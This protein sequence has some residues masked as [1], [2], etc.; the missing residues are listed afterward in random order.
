MSSAQMARLLQGILVAQ[1]TQQQQARGSDMKSMNVQSCPHHVH[2]PGTLEHSTVGGSHVVAKPLSTAHSN[3]SKAKISQNEAFFRFPVGLKE[4]LECCKCGRIYTLP[5][6]EWSAVDSSIFVLVNGGFVWPAVGRPSARANVPALVRGVIEKFLKPIANRTWP[7]PWTQHGFPR[8]KWRE[9]AFVKLFF[10]PSFGAFTLLRAA[11]FVLNADDDAYLE[12]PDA[13]SDERV[14]QVTAA[15]DR[16]VHWCDQID[17]LVRTGARAP[18]LS[19]LED[20]FELYRSIMAYHD[21]VVQAPATTGLLQASLTAEEYERGLHAKDAVVGMLFFCH[22]MIGE[23]PLVLVPTSDQTVIAS[24]FLSALKELAETYY[25]WLGGYVVAEDRKKNPPPPKALPGATT[26]TTTTATA[27]TTD[28]SPSKR[29]RLGDVAMTEDQLLELAIA[30]SLESDQ[31]RPISATGE[32]DDMLSFSSDGGQPKG[33]TNT[34]QSCHANSLIQALFA[35]KPLRR[36]LLLVQRVLRE[37]APPTERSLRVATACLRELA[38]LFGRLDLSRARAVSA[39]R[40]MEMLMVDS[41]LMPGLQHDVTEVKDLMLSTLE[42]VMPSLKATFYGTQHRLEQPSDDAG[43]IAAAIVESTA[44]S[45]WPPADDTDLDGAAADDSVAATSG[46]DAAAASVQPS[47]AEKLTFSDVIVHLRRDECTDDLDDALARSLLGEF[48]Y[49]PHT[50]PNEAILVPPPLLTVSVQRVEYSAAAH[51]ATKID[52]MMR[53]RRTLSLRRYTDVGGD[54]PAHVVAIDRRVARLRER[55]A[56]IERTL[57]ALEMGPTPLTSALGTVATF[58]GANRELS[59]GLLPPTLDAHFGEQLAQLHTHV[60]QQVESLRARANELRVRIDTLMS[61]RDAEATSYA[62]HAVLVHRGG[63][64]VGHYYSFVRASFGD[65]DTWYKCNDERVETVDWNAVAE[66]SFGG[67]SGKDSAYCLI[68]ASPE[69]CAQSLALDD[70]SVLSLYDD[71][72]VAQ[73]SDP[74]MHVSSAFQ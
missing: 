30:K 56:L 41:A 58:L 44:A 5:T 74:A 46:G 71:E 59:L 8:L 24:K 14:R 38:L 29:P 45:L 64:N 16:M 13:A 72:I 51:R 9:G 1:R 40:F 43:V 53:F 3:A 50:R 42:R 57:N 15:I 26:T 49:L 23:E 66:A 62:L 48:A 36:D 28:S 55:L 63:A 27:A 60:V 22:V 6:A 17:E 4:E 69:Y 31:P 32:S 12:L 65:A 52:T 73:L 20:A 21:D 7:A 19:P 39:R 68:Y 34:R 2:A 47:I 67:A 33:L 54:V 18:P 37:Q 10:A 61:E 70:E 11:G 25:E 35:L